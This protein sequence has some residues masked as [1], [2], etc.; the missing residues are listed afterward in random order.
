M[1]D[2]AIA[3]A[4]FAAALVSTR[5]GAEEASKFPCQEDEIAHYTA[6]HVSERI[7]IDGQLDE[8]RYESY[9]HLIQ[10]QVV[11]W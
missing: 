6:Y 11:E 3:A 4:C 1:K 9:C 7:T 2:F 5:A 10:E 8:R